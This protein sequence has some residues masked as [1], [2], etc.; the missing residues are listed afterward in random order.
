MPRYPER[1]GGP[2]DDAARSPTLTEALDFLSGKLCRALESALP[3]LAD[4]FS[5]RAANVADRD[6]REL[7]CE[8]RDAIQEAGPRISSLFAN[9]W[10]SLT[11]SAG[12]SS[13]SS[14]ISNADEL[15]L[16]DFA[17]MDHELAVKALASRLR[18]GCTE[19]LRGVSLRLAFLAGQRGIGWEIDDLIAQALAGVFAEIGLAEAASLELLRVIERQAAGTFGPAIVDLDASLVNRGVLPRLPLTHSRS[20]AARK[21]APESGSPA[22][23]A[24]LF[25]LLQN[26]VAPAA[27]RSATTGGVTPGGV[28]T[29]ATARVDLPP[30]AILASAPGTPATPENM[31]LALD[32]LI[33]RLDS[34]QTVVPAATAA[35]LP[36][37]LLRDLRSSDAGQSL[38]HLSAVTAD[39]VATLFDF[40]FDDEA[41]ADPIKALVARLQIPVLKVALLDRTFFSSKAH[42][43]RRL[44]DGISRAA[45]RIGPGAGNENPLYRRITEIVDRLQ[46]EFRQDTRLFETLREE[47]DAFL[48]RHEAAAD[49]QAKRAVPLVEE[50]ERRELAVVAADQAL[51]SWL[52]RPLPAAV[53]SLL[54]HE[55]REILIRRR[56]AGDD[57]A[58]RA[59]VE[60][61]GEL[62]ASVEVRPDARSRKQLATRLPALVRTIC[63][64]LG[65]LDTAEER[66]L[67]LID[68]LFSVHAAVLRGGRPAVAAPPAA[69]PAAP[70]PAQLAS[71][72]IAKG[73]TLVEKIALAS[74]SAPTAS[75]RSDAALDAVADLRRGDWLEFRNREGGPAR[76]RLSWISPRRGILLFTNPQSPQAMAVAPD[77]LALQIHRGEAAV[78]PVEPLFDRAVSRALEGQKAA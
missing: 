39:I 8:L 64:G 9:K 54:A 21:G 26:A 14:E 1:S 29:T 10:L 5:A 72:R 47:L 31:A 71:E 42:P 68:G 40:I 62:V 27:T 56:L 33:A 30:G 51:A 69:R 25:A 74:G 34:L 17:E 32:R 76:Y 61:I 75:E 18:A 53:A 45:V 2:L 7:L 19:S 28:A 35:S 41:I 24:D 63:N 36:D 15:T 20:A 11:R 38:D 13:P 78:V 70:A 77:A 4:E 3:K 12:R 57:G 23:S 48:D 66:R 67:E 60:T 65:D 44:L 6:Q 43:A 16:V 22:E 58:W 37:N 55:W 49:E 52:S 50:Q 59:A 73:G 46:N